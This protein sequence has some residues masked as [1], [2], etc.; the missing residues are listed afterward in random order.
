MRSRLA[1]ARR[2]LE[3]VL[4]LEPLDRGLV[5]GAQAF[6]ALIP[7]LIVLASV[8]AVNGRSFGDTLVRRFDLHDDAADTVRQTFT[9]PAAS[10][11]L[12]VVGV[13]LVVF[14][15]L[16]FSRALQRVFERSWAIPRRGVRASGWGLLWIGIFALYFT[17]LSLLRGS[18]H[19]ETR[20]AVVLSGDFVVWLLTPYLLLARRIP[21]R[22]LALQASITAVGMTALSAGA[23]IYV[24]RAMSQSAQQFGTIGVAFTLLSLLWGAGLVIVVGAGL[25]AYP[26]TRPADRG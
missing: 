6:S 18:L 15:S 14:S 26:Y 11:T 12:T 19:G 20:L 21:W 4:T 22:R 17:V 7:L 1:P 16:A 8:T 25:G 10:N 5:V 3:H 2:V 24:P 9:A 23:A 13:V